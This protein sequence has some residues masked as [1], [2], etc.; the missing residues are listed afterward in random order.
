MD[1]NIIFFFFFLVFELQ[2]SREGIL[3]YF[4][5]LSFP[6]HPYRLPTNKT[7]H[8]SSSYNEA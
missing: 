4:F 8:Y 5:R 1:K 6:L 7:V 3:R 2:R